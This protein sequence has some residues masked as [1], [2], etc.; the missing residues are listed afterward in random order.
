M[1]RAVFEHTYIKQSFIVYQKFKFNWAS[2]V[3]SGTPTVGSVGWYF[4][5][6]GV[7]GNRK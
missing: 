6:W 2:C 4:C 3:L 1:F 7:G 5:I